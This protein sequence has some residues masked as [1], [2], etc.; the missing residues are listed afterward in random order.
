MAVG[1]SVSI[2]QDRSINQKRRWHASAAS[3]SAP[4]RIADSASARRSARR[5]PRAHP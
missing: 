1:Q 2:D 5:C 4:T 3:R